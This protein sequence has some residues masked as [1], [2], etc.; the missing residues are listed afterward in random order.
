M[1]ESAA[2][3]KLYLASGNAGKLREFQILAAGHAPELELLKEYAALPEFEESAPTF[4]E[5]AAGK[6][7]YYSKHCDEMVFADDSG[8]VVPALDGA[9]G[10]LSARYAGPGASSGQRNMKL[11]SELRGKKGGQRA[12]YFVCVIAAALRGRASVVVSAKVDGEILEEPRGTGG[13]GYDPVFYFP[14][15]GKA[16][17]EL[18]AEE[19]NQQSHRG[20]AFRRLM[21]VLE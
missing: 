16:F 7:L 12:A 19:K 3:K 5:N 8:L 13:F 1:T 2:R 21:E 15:L 4:A 11:L 20:K 9:P 18:S 17:A 10:V 14:A 6:A